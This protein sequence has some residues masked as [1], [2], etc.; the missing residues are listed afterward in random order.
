MAPQ[1]KATFVNNNHYNV[2]EHNNADDAMP[3]VGQKNGMKLADL[4][5]ADYDDEHWEP[6]LDQLTVDEMKEMIAIAGYS[7]AAASSVGKVATVDCDGP[8]AINNNFTGVGS[9]GRSPSS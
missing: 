9:L 5:G 2:Q 7:T 1:F 3:L 4:R 6:L 8:A